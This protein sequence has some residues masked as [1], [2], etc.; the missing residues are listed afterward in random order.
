VTLTPDTNMELLADDIRRQPDLVAAAAG[1][2]VEPLAELASR[3]R[4]PSRIYLVGCGDSLN[5]GMAVRF[6]WERLLGI[7]VQA[8]PALTFS[9]Y[10]IRTVPK[11]ALVIAL[12]QSGTVVRVIEAVR[13]AHSSGV[14]TIAMSGVSTS[15]LLREEASATFATDFPKLGFVPG[16]TSFPY[17]LAIY[18]GLGLAFADAWQTGSDTSAGRQSLGSAADIIAE[19][20]DGIWE[21]ARDHAAAFSRSLPFLLLGTG[22]NYACILFIARKMFEVPQ[23]IALA[24]ESEEYAHDEYSIVSSGVPSLV[25][26]PNGFAAARSREIVNSLLELGSPTAVITDDPAIT[27]R[28][29]RWTYRFGPGL[30]EL[31]RP[32]V[33]TLPGQILTYELGRAIGGSFYGTADPVHR[34]NGDALIYDSELVTTAE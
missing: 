28:R 26:A 23:V 25:I 11:D 34:Q 12:S 16:T 2:F 30:D 33:T 31:Y 21:T 7:P 24:Q 14:R 20:V 18:Y 4:R 15:P 27:D 29:V 1:T 19:A 13:T 3:F 22:P 6:E 17:H 5:V 32:L 9:R 8:V 10:E